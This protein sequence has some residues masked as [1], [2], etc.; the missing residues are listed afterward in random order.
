[1]RIGATFAIAAVSL[2]SACGQGAAP[3]PEKTV[4]QLMAKEVQPTAEIYWGAVQFISDETGNHDI[5]PKDDAEWERVRAAAA[6]LGE[7]GKLL[8]SPAYAEGRGADWVEFS[9]GLVDVAKLAEDAAKAKDT[10]KVF[11]V[12][13]TVYNV[14]SA[15]HVAYP[16]AKGAVEATGEATGG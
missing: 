12:G 16:P 11:E 8:A 15:C 6:T 9:N 7:H 13:G 4:Q 10:D 3:K 1:M 2:L 5:F 14:C